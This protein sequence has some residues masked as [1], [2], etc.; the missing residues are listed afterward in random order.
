MKPSTEQ[1]Y[2]ERIVRVVLH[3]QR[4]LDDELDLDRLASVA[5]FSRFHFHR[6]FRGMTGETVYAYV[7]RIRLERAAGQL[8][9]LDQPI[10]EIALNAGFEAHESFTRAFG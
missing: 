10:T 1:D 6:I 5:A 3:I 4:H 2:R 8:K 7:R 9:H